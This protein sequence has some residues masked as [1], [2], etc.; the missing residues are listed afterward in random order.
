MAG[1]AVGVAGMSLYVLYEAA[2]EQQRARLIETAQGRARMVEAVARFD[3]R[4]SAK[5]PGGSFAGTF[6]R[7]SKV[8]LR[9]GNAANRSGGLAIFLP[10]KFSLM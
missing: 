2:F 3:A 10:S 6:A 4:Y 7:E 5:V 1:I 8:L 9:A